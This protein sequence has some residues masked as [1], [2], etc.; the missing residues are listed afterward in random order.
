MFGETLYGA[1][2]STTILFDHRTEPATSHLTGP[3][4]ELE[5]RKWEKRRCLTRR[6]VKHLHFTLCPHVLLPLGY[7]DLSPNSRY[8]GRS[9]VST[10]LLD[11]LRPRPPGRRLEGL[12]ARLNVWG[13]AT[14]C[15]DTS[16]ANTFLTTVFNFNEINEMV[17]IIWLQLSL[18][19]PSSFS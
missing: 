2:L 17:S 9:I 11:P 1:V 16:N 12:P 10:R 4:I 15:F 19:I 13:N 6:R 18:S 14:R 3:L 8:L 7:L 5:L